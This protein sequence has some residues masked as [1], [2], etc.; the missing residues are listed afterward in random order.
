MSDAG[1]QNRTRLETEAIV[2][3]YGMSRL[4]SEYL[5]RLGFGSWTVA[6]E[7]AA[8]SLQEPASSFRNLRD[9]FDPIHP[10]LRQGRHK[11]PLRQSRQRVIDELAD[12]SDDALIE[13]IR[14]ILARDES[15][16]PPRRS[17]C[18][19][20]SPSAPTMSRNGCSP[21]G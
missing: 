8:A 13:L 1:D 6:F 11:R 21:G 4:D 2:V 10:N 12:V 14:R 19:L 16:Q 17:I 7:N 3:G 5:G 20:W 9:E 18:L 15:R